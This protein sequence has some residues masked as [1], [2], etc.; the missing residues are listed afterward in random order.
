MMNVSQIIRHPSIWRLLGQ[1]LVKIVLPFLL[2]LGLMLAGGM[3]ELAI[4]DQT[5]P[6]IATLKLYDRSLGASTQYIGACEGNVDFN[7]SDLE[8]LGLNTYR[9]YGGMSRWETEDDDGIY[10]YPSIAQIKANPDVVNWD[11]WDRVMTQ[12]E[13]GSDYAF[14]GDPTELWQG[15]ASTLLSALKE[16]HIRPVLTLRNSDPGWDP[17][18]ALQLNPPRT[19]ADW[20]EWWQH[21]FAT[22]YWLNVRHDYQV[23]DFELHNEPDNRQQGWGGNQADYFE[24][25][26]VGADAIAH[27]YQTYLPDRDFHIHA[28]KTVGHSLWPA[29]TLDAIPTYFDQVNVHNYDWDISA[30]VRQVRGWMQG[31]IHERSPLWLGEW[32]TYTDGYDDLS[33]SLNLIKNMIRMSQPGDTYVYGSHLFSLYDWGRGDF[34]GL[35]DAEGHRRLSYYALRMGTRALQGGRPVLLT[36]ISDDAVMAIATQDDQNQINL[37]LVNDQPQAHTLAVDLSALVSDG[38]GTLWEF[39]ETVQD[40]A[41]APLVVTQGELQLTLPAYSSQLAIIPA[42]PLPNAILN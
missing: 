23:D 8:D 17:D 34:A 5:S 4:A 22:V 27:V 6:A 7:L 14:S 36:G 37:L 9:I 15:S 31:T 2:G 19:E 35:I 33:F 3:T 16:A 41:I 38:T 21:V 11:W 24:L 29:D 26:R 12:P 20:N 40:E 10:G 18:W 42:A 28:P 25:A 39:S 30:Y 1:I 13:G 32:G